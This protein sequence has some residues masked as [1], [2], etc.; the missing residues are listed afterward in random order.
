[1]SSGVPPPVPQK[2]FFSFQ[3]STL[4]FNKKSL[5]KSPKNEKNLCSGVGKAGKIARFGKFF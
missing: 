2:N 1:V 3:A 5:Q 4:F